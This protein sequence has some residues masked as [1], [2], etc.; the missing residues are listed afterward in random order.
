[1]AASDRLP[2]PNPGL[3]KTMQ[4]MPP[5]RVKRLISRLKRIPVLSRLDWRLYLLRD[6][7]ATKV[8]TR[9]KDTLTPFG[10]R[11]TT[12]VHPAYELMRSGAFEPEET[13]IFVKLL[14]LTDVFVDIGANLGYYCCFALQRHKAVVAFEPQSQ[15]LRC[16][17]QNL[18][19]NGWFDKVEIFPVALSSAPGMLE[20]FGA[21]GPSA[22][23]VRDWAGYS[24]RFK[25]TVPVNTLDNVLAGRFAGKRLLVKIDVEGAEFQVLQGAVATV[26]RMPRPMWLIEVC[27]DEYHPSGV[28]P[29]YL[30]IFTLFWDNGYECY[31]ADGHCTPIAPADVRRWLETGVR[32]VKTFNY[33]FVDKA[34]GLPEFLNRSA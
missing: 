30:G 34:I 31:G 17:Y 21:S 32:D 2:G 16:L 4:P 3:E 23:L 8:W 20:L 5:G 6:L 9:T 33:V 22:S 10:F 27:F 15:N 14:D 24:S 18:A 7:W 12:R 25:Q 11:L 1:M 26:S 28:N 13:R 29:D 19:S